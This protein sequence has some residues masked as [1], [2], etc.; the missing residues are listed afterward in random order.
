MQQPE[1]LQDYPEA[2]YAR[3][4]QALD[5]AVQQDRVIWLFHEALTGRSALRPLCDIL[6]IPNVPEISLPPLPVEEEP[7]LPVALRDELRKLLA[8]QY[9]AARRKFAD[10]LPADWD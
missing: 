8:P 3:L 4:F 7:V 10:Q 9:R 2:D 1:R 6:D 5:T